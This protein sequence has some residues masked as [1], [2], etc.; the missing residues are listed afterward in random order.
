MRTA[1]LI[2]ATVAACFVV[3]A[4][5]AHSAEAPPVIKGCTKAFVNGKPACL[6]T[7]DR[8]RKRFEAEYVLVD[9]SCRGGK[10]RKASI[11]QRRHDDPLLV[12]PNGEITLATALEAA[13]LPGAKTQ[14]GDIG[15]LPDVSFALEVIAGNLD[16]LT[17]EQRAAYTAATT[18]IASKQA[19]KRRLVSPAEQSRDLG[20]IDD[21]R[22]VM[23]AHGYAFPRLI[24]LSFADDQGGE[25]PTVL[26][27]T[28]PGDILGTSNTC[29]IFILGAG[30]AESPDEVRVTLSHEVATA[31][32]TRST[33]PWRRH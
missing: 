7:G 21:A 29:D 4:S 1:G 26:A 19:L 10:L 16:K 11:A 5:T 8:C 18:P 23:A 28:S 2:A 17:D 6:R 31:P 20:Y 13:N 14:K 15:A 27:Y 33:R 12:K 3:G 25:G 24:T 30:R 32:S 9:L 22:R